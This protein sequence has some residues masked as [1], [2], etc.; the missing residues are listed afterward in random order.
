MLLLVIMCISFTTFSISCDDKK[1]KDPI[2]E[3][4]NFQVSFNLNTVQL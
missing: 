1:K 4:I 2:G 3:M